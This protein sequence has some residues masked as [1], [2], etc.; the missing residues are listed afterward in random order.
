[1]KI[2][3]PS[4]PKSQSRANIPA[5]V[6]H[7]KSGKHPSNGL[8][9][10]ARLLLRTADCRT[11]N[12]F[13]CWCCVTRLNGIAGSVPKKRAGHFQ[14]GRAHWCLD[15]CTQTLSTTNIPCAG[16]LI[17]VEFGVR[18]LSMTSSPQ[19]S[20][21]DYLT[22]NPYPLHC[23]FCRKVMSY[24]SCPDTTVGHPQQRLS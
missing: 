18:R 10:R 6:P 14:N 12:I 11:E 13:V 20:K 2:G 22:G 9:S 7:P 23:P 24:L 1:M 15:E 5:M 4:Q 19:T 17:A 8:L 16:P 3:R 21:K